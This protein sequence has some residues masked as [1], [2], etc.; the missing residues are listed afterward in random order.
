MQRRF[1]SPVRLACGV[2]EEW[3]HPGRNHRNSI[4]DVDRRNA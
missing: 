2:H 1:L 4:E 3:Q